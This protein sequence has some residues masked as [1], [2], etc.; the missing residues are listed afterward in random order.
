MGVLRQ[1]RLLVVS[2]GCASSTSK[3][4]LLP[5]RISLGML[6]LLE[7]DVRDEALEEEDVR[8]KED[9]DC[10]F[11]CRFDWSSSPSRQAIRDFL[12]IK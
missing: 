1:G 4:L 2:V 12:S 8:D 11:V 3:N 6:K 9:D 10:R 5:P 7:E